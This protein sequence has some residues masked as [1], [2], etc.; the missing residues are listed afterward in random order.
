MAAIGTK[1]ITVKF[2][3]EINEMVFFLSWFDITA[4]YS[5][6]K[7]SFMKPISNASCV[8]FMIQVYEILFIELYGDN[9]IPNTSRS[10][11]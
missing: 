9:F 2:I 7:K 11:R 6:L 4:H 1:L 10:N 3:I 5:R 8:V